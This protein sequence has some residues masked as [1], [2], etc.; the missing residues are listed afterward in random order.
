[1]SSLI[2]LVYALAVVK[3][4]AFIAVSAASLLG[5]LG[6]SVVAAVRRW[7]HLRRE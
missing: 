7:Q 5:S 2:S 4:V 3:D 6:V 1:V